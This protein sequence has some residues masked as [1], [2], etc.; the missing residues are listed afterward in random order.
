MDT[1]PRDPELTPDDYSAAIRVLD[2]AACSTTI[3]N[4]S[5]YRLHLLARL[6]QLVLALYLG[7]PSPFART[8]PE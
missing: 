1:T 2:S 5:S 4:A 6:N 3:W 7:K 8:D